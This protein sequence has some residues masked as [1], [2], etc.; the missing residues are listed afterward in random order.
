VTVL[1]IDPQ[2]PTVDVDATPRLIE[3]T[4]AQNACPQPRNEVHSSD[5][6]MSTILAVEDDGALALDLGDGAVAELNGAANLGVKLG[7]DVSRPGHVVGG[8][9]VEDPVVVVVLLHQ[10][11][12][13]EDLLL[14]DVD[15][16]VGFY[17]RGR[18]CHDIGVD[19]DNERLV[20]DDV[21]S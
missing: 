20:E 2:H 12:I 10:I 14:L 7:E 5:Y 21:V 16:T 8:T 9:G 13:G 4:E 15:N 1:V 6:A 3:L 11:E 17:R 18:G 19:D